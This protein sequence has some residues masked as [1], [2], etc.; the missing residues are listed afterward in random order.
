MVRQ[1]TIHDLARVVRAY[2][3]P[4]KTRMRSNKYQK[5]LTVIG[6]MPLMNYC[7]RILATLSLAS[8]KHSVR[9]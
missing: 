2:V 7:T 8:R 3:Q 4:A 5:Y 6:L 1:Q 9:I